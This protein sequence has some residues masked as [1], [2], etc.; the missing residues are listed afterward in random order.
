MKPKEQTKTLIEAASSC[1]HWNILFFSKYFM[2]CE[3]F[4]NFSFKNIE[5][6]CFNIKN[7]FVNSDSFHI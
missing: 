1:L 4:E 5:S 2:I 3:I 7:R 6:S